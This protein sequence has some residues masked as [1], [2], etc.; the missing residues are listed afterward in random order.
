MIRGQVPVRGPRFGDPYS[1]SREI[2]TKYQSHQ[3]KQVLDLTATVTFGSV[4][5][6]IQIQMLALPICS[7]LDKFLLSAK[8]PVR[9][10]VGTC[11]LPA[12]TTRCLLNTAAVCF[13]PPPIEVRVAGA[14]ATGQKPPW[15]GALTHLQSRDR[16]N[17]EVGEGGGERST[18]VWRR[19]APQAASDGLCFTTCKSITGWKTRQG[20]RFV[21][22]PSTSVNWQ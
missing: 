2:A 3:A 9:Q 22:M 21:H 4:T 17:G 5:I 8:Q 14:V 12:P 6:D 13:S 20:R 18:H 10:P 1:R 15:H 19:G 11:A 16:L 7:S